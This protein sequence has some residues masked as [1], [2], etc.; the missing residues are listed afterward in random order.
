MR[1]CWVPQ[2]SYSG[3][4]QNWGPSRVQV[5]GEQRSQWEWGSSHETRRPWASLPPSW[6]TGH[7]GH[8][9][10]KEGNSKSRGRVHPLLPATWE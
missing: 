7:V 9:V 6:R 3:P 10:L 2:V 1:Y 8:Q 5:W 4:K